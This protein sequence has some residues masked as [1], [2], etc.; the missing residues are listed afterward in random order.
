[1]PNERYTVEQVYPEFTEGSFSQVV[2]AS[3]DKEAL[4]SGTV[5]MDDEGNFVGEDDMEAQLEQILENINH[6]LAAVGAEPKHL[7]RIRYYT[8]D[9]DAF[10]DV[11]LDPIS[12][13]LDEDNLPTSTLLGVESLESHEYLLEIDAK[14]VLDEG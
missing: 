1:M 14:A 9:V 4:I 5:A 12:E 10:M 3:G 7:V 8:V 11:A 2:V 13:F 6:S